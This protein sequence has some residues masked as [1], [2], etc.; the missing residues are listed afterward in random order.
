LGLHC[1]F[2]RRG[3]SAHGGTCTPTAISTTAP[4]RPVMG[5]FFATHGVTHLAPEQFFGIAFWIGFSSSF[6]FD[7]GKENLKSKGWQ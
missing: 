6:G 2:R 4:T 5:I 1:D 3:A 7:H